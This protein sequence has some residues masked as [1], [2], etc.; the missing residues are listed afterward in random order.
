MLKL[1]TTPSTVQTQL[2]GLQP[3]LAGKVLVPCP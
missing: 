2:D 1:N 3:A